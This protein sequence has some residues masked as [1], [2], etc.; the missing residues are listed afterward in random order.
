[1]GSH[2][3]VHCFFLFFKF[4]AKLHEANVSISVISDHRSSTADE[5]K[6]LLKTEHLPAL[7]SPPSTVCVQEQQPGWV[8]IHSAYHTGH[9]GA[10]F[11]NIG[12]I[13]LHAGVHMTQR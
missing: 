8:I 5:E 9:N 11:W 4:S 6:D 1:M 12:R 7:Y 10:V 13:F 3:C 2:E